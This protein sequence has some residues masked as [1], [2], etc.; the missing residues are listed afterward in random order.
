MSN[1]IN[2]L[3]ICLSAGFGGL[4]MYPMRVGVVMMPLGCKVYGIGQT[5]TPTNTRM[6]ETF[7]GVLSLASRGEGYQKLLRLAQWIKQRD[8]DVVH[9]H[10]SSDLTLAVLLKKLCHFKLIYTD[11]MGVKRPKKDF[12]HRFIYRNLDLVLSISKFAREQN[13]KAFPMPESKIQLLWNGTEIVEVE[14]IEL[15]LKTEL[16]LPSGT[17]L[18]GSVGRLSNGKGHLELLKAFNQLVRSQ[19]H[20]IIVG[21]LTAETGGSTEYVQMLQSYVAENDLQNKVTFYGFTD[22]PDTLLKTIDVVVIPSHNEAFG[23]TVIEAMAARKAII[24][25]SRGAIPELLEDTGVI[26]DPFDTQ[27][28][29]DAIDNLSSSVE[30]RNRLSNLARKR[31]CEL[32]D[33]KKHVYTLLDMYKTC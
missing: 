23:L 32:F 1:K 2:V 13:L 25:S 9:C 16:S 22:K 18:V 21:G 26:V 12:Y 7:D 5:D 20:L 3:H 10:K 17:I 29:A 28:F 6:V 24:G 31:A 30:E 33:Q 8:I 19:V 27:A 4:E 15:D 11:H 14:D